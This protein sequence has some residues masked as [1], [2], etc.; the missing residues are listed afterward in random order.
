MPNFYP[1]VSHQTPGSFCEI[2]NVSEVSDLEYGM[3]F[4]FPQYR[5]ET[6][7]RFYQFSCKYHLHPGIVY[8]LMPFLAKKYKWGVEERLWFCF[9]NGHT[10]NPV[11]SKI[12]FDLYPSF[13]NLNVASLT[14][15]FNENWSRLDW[16]GDRRHQKRDFPEA[17]KRYKELCGKNQEDFF[18]TLLS[19][20]DPFVNFQQV[21]A[22]LIQPRYD[23]FGEDNKPYVSRLNLKRSLDLDSAE[24]YAR[25]MGLIGWHNVKLY[26]LG[27]MAGFGYTEY[28]RAMR[29]NID[30]DTLMLDDPGSGSH[31]NGLCI[32]LGRDDLNYVTGGAEDKNRPNTTNFDG[33]YAPEV[34]SWLEEEA[35]ELLKEAKLRM[36]GN[37]DVSYFTLESAF[38]TYKSMHYAKGNGKGRYPGCYMDMLYD[39]IK[40]AQTSWPEVDFWE[41]WEAREQNLPKH[42]LREFNPKDA[43]VTKEKA[44]HYRLTGQMV[45]MDEEWPC[46]KNDYNDSINALQALES[47]GDIIS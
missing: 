44:D 14:K 5:R 43:G 16:D 17:V 10:E 42:L 29:L 32:V 22:A 37:H 47:N 24:K 7:L 31:R 9:L 34:L 23:V 36:P 2:L 30:C 8:M 46:F 33:N 27:R 45:G 13:E 11:T 21:W 1:P 40:K 20:D 19:T 28:L 39:R 6:F 35:A 15:W 3:D 18:L 26:S 4:R 12:I 41:F 25:K 38:C